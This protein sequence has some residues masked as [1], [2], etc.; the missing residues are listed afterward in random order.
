MMQ[1]SK[2]ESQPEAFNIGQLQNEVQQE[3]NM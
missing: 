1:D 2:K 3:N